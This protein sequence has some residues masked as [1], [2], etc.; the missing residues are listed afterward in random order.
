METRPQDKET[1]Q[2]PQ[3]RYAVKDDIQ[4]GRTRRLSLFYYFT[5]DE[6]NK[7]RNKIKGEVTRAK[8]LGELPA[9]TAKNSRSASP[10]FVQF[11]LR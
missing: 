1:A 3:Q 5:D 10:K 6:F 7:V 2:K 11:Y 8:G 9:E 4:R